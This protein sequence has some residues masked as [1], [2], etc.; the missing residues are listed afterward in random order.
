[1]LMREVFS[2]LIWSFF[3]KL[4]L[5]YACLQSYKTPTELYFLLSETVLRSGAPTAVF[6]VNLFIY[7]L[8]F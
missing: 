2:C 3:F 6:Q 1:M 5:S 7:L 4:V 8:H